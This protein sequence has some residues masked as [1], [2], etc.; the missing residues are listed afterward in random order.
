MAITIPDKCIKELDVFFANKTIH[1]VNRDTYLICNL[2][3]T[4]N[5]INISLVFL[6]DWDS[7]ESDSFNQVIIE[8]KGAVFQFPCYWVSVPKELA[9]G[10]ITY[11]INTFYD[12]Y[13]SRWIGNNSSAG[14]NTGAG[15]MTGPNIGTN[16]CGC[17][18]GFVNPYPPC[19][20][21]V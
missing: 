8:G 11:I 1:D 20:N 7:L 21:L 15:S 10:Y 13:V 4:L 3:D 16:N 2:N 17:N 12:E 19:N 9:M 14:G 5:K 6:R 18:N